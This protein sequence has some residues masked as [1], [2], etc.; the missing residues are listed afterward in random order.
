[1]QSPNPSPRQ[2]PTPSVGALIRDWRQRRRMSQLDLAC[3][4]DISTRHLSFLETGRSA[5]SRDMVLRL[6]DRLEAPLRIR[7][8][9]LL[10]A[11]YA[12]AFAERPLNDPMLGAARQ[13]LDRLLKAHEPFPAL[14][15]DRAWNLVAA[16]GAI[17]PL[18]EGVSPALLQPPV[19]LMRLTLHP[20]G[21]APRIENFGQWRAH[22]LHRLRRQAELAADDG[23]SALVAEITAFPAPNHDHH[24]DPP[25]DLLAVPLRIKSPLGPLSF[26]SATMVFDAPLDVTLSELILET[27]LPAD[28]ETGA[29]LTA[30]LGGAKGG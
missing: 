25:A 10:A 21:M 4:A 29:R 12:P 6:A 1:M 22:L 13:A 2:S 14:A 26:W 8:N 16:N 24:D 15:A 17:A 11:G 28:A 23:L 30:L 19:N 18:V 27:F 3:E 5:P 7:N 20:Q 9:M